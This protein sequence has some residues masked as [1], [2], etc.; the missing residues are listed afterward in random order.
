MTDTDINPFP[1]T[2]FA[3]MISGKML[4]EFSG[5]WLSETDA[6]LVESMLIEQYPT[7]TICAY[8]AKKEVTYSTWS[9]TVKFKD[10]ADEAAFIMQESNV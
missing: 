9:V 8:D 5:R 6:K 4:W 3:K 10:K 7:A 1:K 2:R